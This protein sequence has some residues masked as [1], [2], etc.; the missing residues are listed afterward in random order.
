MY[1]KS[2]KCSIHMFFSR[3]LLQESALN[4]RRRAIEKVLQGDHKGLVTVRV[5]VVCSY[6]S[7]C[8]YVCVRTLYVCLIVAI[9]SI[10]LC[11]GA[12]AEVAA[13]VCVTKDDCSMEKVN[14]MRGM[15]NPMFALKIFVRKT[16]TDWL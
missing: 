13:V 7:V 15:S 4:S 9:K 3:K 11:T 1:K 16:I 12:A 14:I 8:A 10:V 6:L 2:I 5:C